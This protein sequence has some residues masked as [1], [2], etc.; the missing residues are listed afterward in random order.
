MV[1][2]YIE[3]TS[4]SIDITINNS[5]SQFADIGELFA[6]NG[7]TDHPASSGNTYPSS[8]QH[9]SIEESDPAQTDYIENFKPNQ[10]VKYTVQSGDSIG[11]IAEEFGV[12]INTIVWANNL[13]NPNVLSTGQVLKILPV[14][15][16]IHTIK[17]GDTIATIAKKYRADE[18]KI[19]AFNKLSANEAL[20][21]GD[22][23]I[24]PNGELSMPVPSVKAI[25]HKSG[26]PGYSPI[27]N[28][29]CVPFVQAHGYADLHG[30]AYQWKKYINTPEPTI[31]GVVVL[32]GGRYGHVALITAVKPDSIQVVEQNYFGPHIVDHREIAINDRAVVGFITK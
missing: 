28:G 18:E 30:N 17:T 7:Q 2:N 25:A 14:T 3:E 4:A 29:Q 21:A 15:G 32:K 13:S 24:V 20:A 6:Y 8:A 1:K 26:I 12:S 9:N 27:G 19:I 16:V 31:G 10:V 22:E 5:S 23:I 11:N